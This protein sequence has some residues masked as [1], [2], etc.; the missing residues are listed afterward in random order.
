M[1][2]RAHSRLIGAAIGLPLLTQVGPAATWLRWPTIWLMPRLK[3][4][5]RAR[6]V[7]ITFDDGPDPTSTPLFLDELDRLGW[8]ATFFVLGSMARSSPDVLRRVVGAGHEVGIHG[9]QHRSHLLMTPGQVHR[10]LARAV[11]SVTDITGIAPR[12]FRPP[13]GELS[14]GSVVAAR[15]LRLR[16]V[17]W[18]TWGRD[19][20]DG[21]TPE[22]I[23]TTVV[24]RLRPGATVL[25]HDSDCTSTPGSWRATLGSL[26]LLAR[27]LDPDVTVGPLRDHFG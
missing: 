13:Y 22:S 8:T 2:S 27:H 15:R 1:Q 18:S 21:A 11:S 25:L 23:T 16:P 4:V 9:D 6:H 24:S 5:G 3:G 20:V 10:D 19:W 17:L 12:W 26:A 14:I 7:A